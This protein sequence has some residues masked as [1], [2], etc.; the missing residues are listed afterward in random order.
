MLG[1]MQETGQRPWFSADQTPSRLKCLR[2][3]LVGLLTLTY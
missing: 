3:D 2:R 1:G